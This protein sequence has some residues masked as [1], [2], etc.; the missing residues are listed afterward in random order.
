[1]SGNPA[2][3][4][5]LRHRIGISGPL[6]FRDFMEQALYHPEHGY[7]A[8]GKGAT[9]RKGDYF[10]NVSVGPLF[11]KLLAMQFREMWER[12]GAPAQFTIVEQGADNGNFARDVLAALAADAPGFA[13]AVNYI[14]IE[15]FPLL[16][17]RQRETLAGLPRVEWR[18]ALEKLDPFRGVHFSNELVDAMPV[19]LVKFTGGEMEGALRSDWKNDGFAWADAPVSS[20]KL[21]RHLEKLPRDPGENYTTEINLD[22]PAWLESLSSRLDAGYI[23]IADYGH[24]RAVYYSPERNEETLACYFKHQ[25]EERVVLLQNT[26][27][28]DITAHVDFTSLAECAASP[29]SG[30]RGLRRPAPFH[31]RPRQAGV[32]RHGR[33]AERGKT[34]SL[35]QFNTLM[36]PNFMGMQFKFLALEKILP[37]AADA[38]L[39]GFQLSPAPRALLWD[40]RDQGR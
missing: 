38:P 21:V 27:L 14:I 11:G 36:H 1:M 24:P 12:M 26:G 32:P 2:L 10:T 18:D 7:Y 40:C 19:H 25:R 30:G 5:F 3:I 34:K 15:P 35:R 4:E 22:A 31:G 13:S 33:A 29:R 16:E 8:S 37:P 28:A 20:E 9:G 39:A 6:P 23:L 17:K